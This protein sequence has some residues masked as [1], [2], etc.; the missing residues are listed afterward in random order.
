MSTVV[1]DKK[2]ELVMRLVH[3]FVTQE[4]YT[5]I[6]VNGVKNEIWLE[7]IDGPYRIVRINSNYIHNKEQY[8]F[9]IFKTKN[10]I[11]QIKKKTLSIKMNTLNIFL[12]LNSDVNLENNK[13]ISSVVINNS[14]DI[15][16]NDLIVNSYP[17]IKDKLINNEKG[18]DLIINVT[19]DINQKTAT[20][21][22]QYEAT[23]K[24]KKIIV[25]NVIIG[26]CVLVYLLCLINPNITYLLANSR[27]YVRNGEWYRL[28]TCTLVHAGIIHLLCN[29]YSLYIVGTQLENVIGKLKFTIVYIISA[30]SGSLLSIIFSSSYS[31]GASGA[32]FGLLGSLLYFGYHY[33]LYLSNVIKSQLIPIIVLNLALGFMIPGIDNIAHI[34]GLIGGY[35]ATMAVGIP[36]KSSKSERINGTIVLILYL[37]FIIAMG[38]FK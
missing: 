17:N 23:F 25:T 20:E 18:I 3:Y 27:L 24:P 28:L 13:N 11:D 34:G 33:R 16:K 14:K 7:N 35:L 22:K 2:E 21:N 6:V 15:K 26:L 30:L 19:N 31:V 38:I 29:M 10:I 9:D 37:L 12:D 36:N 4:N 32:I 8:N 5:P 1:M